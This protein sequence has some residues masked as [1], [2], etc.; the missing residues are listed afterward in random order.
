MPETRTVLVADDD[1]NDFIILRRAFQ[2]AG[3]AHRLV[4][5]LDGE[6]A[7]DYLSGKSPFEDRVLYPAP[8]LLLLDLKMPRVNGFD[9][10]AWLQGR[11]D[12]DALNVVVLSASQLEADR[13]QAT[14]LGAD[15][16]CTK[17]HDFDELVKLARDLDARWASQLR[18]AGAPGIS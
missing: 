6:A 8:S 4:H 1:E 12:L 17:P 7:I 9:V 14:Q 15:D 18:G 16:Y 5:V 3:L 11:S 10:L 2:K 13:N